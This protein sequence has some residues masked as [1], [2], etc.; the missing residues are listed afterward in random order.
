MDKYLEK[1]FK[2][3]KYARGIKEGTFAD[4]DLTKKSKVVNDFRQWLMKTSEDLPFKYSYFLNG[5]LDEKEKEVIIEVNKGIFDSVLGGLQQLEKSKH[6][7]AVTKYAYTF[8]ER[9]TDNEELK[10]Y[11]IWNP[12]REV[13]RTNHSLASTLKEA[14]MFGLNVPTIIMQV[15]SN[16]SLNHRKLKDLVVNGNKTLVIGAYG[17]RRDED[18]ERKERKLEII[19]NSPILT[20]PEI[21]IETFSKDYGDSF[22]QAVV[23]RKTRKN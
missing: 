7:I 2:E 23:L 22:N 8:D 9:Y 16:M 4:L 10:K 20:T 15:P 19:S 14:D 5:I 12:S 11:I 13:A 21:E 17:S 6:L 1:V 18:R 3:Y